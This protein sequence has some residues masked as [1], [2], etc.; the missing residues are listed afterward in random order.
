MIWGTKS[1]LKLSRTNCS[2]DGFTCLERTRYI[3]NFEKFGDNVNATLIIKEWI[4]VSKWFQTNCSKLNISRAAEWI[5]CFFSNKCIFRSD[6][7]SLNCST[8]FSS[9]YRCRSPKTSTSNT[10]V[11]SNLVIEDRNTNGIADNILSLSCIDPVINSRV[12]SDFTSICNNMEGVDVVYFSSKLL[13]NV[14]NFLIFQ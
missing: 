6:I 10:K 12:Q 1:E 7:I 11:S 9:S 2:S 5:K 14:Y 3:R 8:N 4:E 13:L